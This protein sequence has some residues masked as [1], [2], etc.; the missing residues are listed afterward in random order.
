MDKFRYCLSPKVFLGE[1]PSPNPKK[2]QIDTEAWLLTDRCAK[3]SRYC[4]F[5]CQAKRKSRIHGSKAV[6]LIYS[7]LTTLPAIAILTYCPPNAAMRI[8][9]TRARCLDVKDAVH[10]AC[11]LLFIIVVALV[12]YRHF[13]QGKVCAHY[14]FT[15]RTSSSMN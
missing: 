9:R 6:L 13:W 5:N 10:R 12:V 15:P 8:R 1:S 14:A 2:D 11:L 7:S 4:H 3:P